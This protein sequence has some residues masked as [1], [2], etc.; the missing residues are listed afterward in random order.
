MGDTDPAW[1]LDDQSFEKMRESMFMNHSK[2]L[3]LYDELSTF[4]AQLNICR[5]HG[6]AESHEVALFLQLYG[7][8]AWIWRTGTEITCTT[9]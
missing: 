4:L 1:L 6:V 8:D 2:L 7:A 3:G 9:V 5:G